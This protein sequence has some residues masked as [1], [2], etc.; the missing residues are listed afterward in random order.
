MYLGS[1]VTST[2]GGGEVGLRRSKI[3]QK[4]K[5]AFMW[6]REIWMGEIYRIA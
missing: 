1:L 5:V 4:A 2:G 6:I 3:I